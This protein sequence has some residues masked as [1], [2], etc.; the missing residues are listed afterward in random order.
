MGNMCNITLVYRNY[1]I[2]INCPEH[3]S[4][5]IDLPVGTGETYILG[6]WGNELHQLPPPDTLCGSTVRKRGSN[7]GVCPPTLTT[8]YTC[9]VLYCIVLHCIALRC[10]ALYCINN[11]YLLY[12]KQNTEKRTLI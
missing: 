7:P 10:I 2:I 5:H 9:I 12:F 6:V 4:P 11:I 1:V 3:L 8:L